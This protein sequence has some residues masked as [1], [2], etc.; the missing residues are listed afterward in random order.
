MSISLVEEVY[1]HF[2]VTD[3][4]Q[5]SLISAQRDINILMKTVNEI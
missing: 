4:V 2:D 1:Q 3:G 5:T